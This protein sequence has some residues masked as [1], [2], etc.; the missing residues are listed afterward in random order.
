[1]L[2]PVLRAPALG[3]RALRR[4]RGEVHRRRGHGRLRRT[5][6]ARGRPRARRARCARR[7]RGRPGAERGQPGARPARAHRRQ[8]R[9]GGR[10]A[11][12]P[13]VRGR[14]DGRG[15]RRQHGR[16]PA[17]GRAGGRHPRR[18]DDLPGDRARRS[19]IA[20]ASRCEAKGKAEPIP[21][22]EAL[23]ARARYGVDVAQRGRR[24]ARRAPTRS[25]TCSSRRSRGSSASGRRSSSRSSAFRAS[26]RAGSS[27][28]SP[29]AVD[30]DPELIVFWRQGRSLP[31]GEGV[32]FWAL[33][34]MVKAQ[35]G[36]LETDSAEAAE[37]KL[38]ET[39]A[40]LVPDAERARAGSRAI[41]GALVGLS[42]EEDGGGRPPRRGVRGL[43]ALL[44]GA[45]RAAAARARLRGSA[46]GRR[47]PARLRRLPRR[48]GDGLAASRH[49]DG[50]A[51]SCSSAGPAGA[52]ASRTPPPSRSHRSPR[53]RRRASSRSLLE[54][55]RH[56]GREPGAASRAR[57]RQPALRRGVRAHG[58][59]ARSRS[60]G[61]GAASRDR[62]GHRRRAARRALGRGE[63]AHPG[64]GR[65]RQGLLERRARRDERA[66]ALDGGGAA[67]RG[68]SERSSCGGSGAPRW[69]RRPSTRSATSSSA[70]S[71]MDRSRAAARAEK[72][73]RAAEWIET[74]GADRED[75]AEML[76][77]H[78]ASALEFARASGQ[79]VDAI[80]DRAR[81]ALFEAGER[82]YGL[83]A[84]ASAAGFYRDAVE[85]WPPGEPGRGT[86]AVPLREVGRPVGLEP[87]TLCPSSR[88]LATCSWPKMNAKWPPKPRSHWANTTG[89]VPIVPVSDAAGRAGGR[90]DRRRRALAGEGVRPQRALAVRHAPRRR[91]Q[92]GR[93][94][95]RERSPWRRSSA[96]TRCGRG[97]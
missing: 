52:E 62:P 89:F 78:Y 90:A 34:E 35:A 63:D 11:R 60:D 92:G 76:A 10:R 65:D 68:S 37:T 43:A 73:R 55:D 69:R 4:N 40:D 61:R 13:P 31:Y 16:P 54:R 30:A 48:L 86:T 49:R 94:L 22:W 58:R 84:Y 74:L 24:S 38:I 36:I 28:S 51:R 93:A 88:R 3:D 66:P 20:T 44:R 14:G 1:M 72:H 79:P 5:G 2:S 8:H 71:P 56:A 91:R 9:R 19:S 81:V 6:R 25:S 70:T 42:A 85:L 17:G 21:V 46:L 7:P 50:A 83:Y 80:A 32:A 15:R 82:A 29:Q 67:A 97:R 18:R 27:G 87:S 23:G 77:H 95:P 12:R 75:R 26:A 39:V 33:A 53:R 45:R 96:P 47:Q 59:R 41:C 64:R 57:G